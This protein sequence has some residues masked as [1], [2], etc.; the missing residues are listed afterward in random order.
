MR[1]SICQSFVIV[2]LV[3]SLAACGSTAE[4]P[5]G[6]LDARLGAAGRSRCAASRGGDAA[7]A[8]PDGSRGPGG[9]PGDCRGPGDHHTGR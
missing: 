4:R 1:R 9:R 6:W 5:Y 2:G 3:L 7:V 8:R